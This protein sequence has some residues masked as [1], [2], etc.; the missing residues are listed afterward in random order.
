ML[1]FFGQ[2]HGEIGIKLVLILVFLPISPLSSGSITPALTEGY[3]YRKTILFGAILQVLGFFAS[4]YAKETWHMFCT[5]GILTGIG[6][7]LAFTPAVGIISLYFDKYRHFASTLVNVGVAAGIMVFSFFH[8]WLLMQMGWRYAMEVVAGVVTVLL[9]CGF[10]MK[11][12]KRDAEVVVVA[13][14]AENR[15]SGAKEAMHVE[16]FRNPL[17]YLLLIQ[18]QAIIADN[19]FLYNAP[20]YLEKVHGWDSASAAFILT[21]HGI[22]SM[23][24]RIPINLLN[25]FPN[26][27]AKVSRSVQV[28]FGIIMLCGASTMALLLP[29]TVPC[30]LLYLAAILN[31]AGEAFFISY[32]PS[33]L[34]NNLGTESLTAS[35]GYLSFTWGL[36]TLLLFPTS[37]A[38]IDATDNIRLC[39]TV[40]IGLCGVAFIA[41]ALL[42]CMKTKIRKTQTSQRSLTRDEQFPLNEDDIRI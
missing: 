12:P 34:M 21:V 11:R 17:F 32:Q 14:T 19:V 9:V 39:F 29:S 5:L 28:G 16:F 4:S 7:G 6:S 35:F 15:K 42:K 3:G 30:S 40:A 36:V 41:L 24:C 1:A 18:G 25:A 22:A 27:A 38:I 23:C 8:N 31:G 20:M 26:Y 33:L 13:E 10:V 37:G 2:I